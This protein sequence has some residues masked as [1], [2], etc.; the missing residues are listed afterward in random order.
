MKYLLTIPMT[1]AVTIGAALALVLIPAY[2]I[3][4]TAYHLSEGMLSKVKA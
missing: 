3:V 4:A 1:V 2:F